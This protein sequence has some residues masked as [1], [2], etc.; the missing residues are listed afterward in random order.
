MNCLRRCL[1]FLVLWIF[2][3]C[4]LLPSALAADHI[5]RIFVNGKIWTGDDAHPSAEAL[6]I[7]GDKI[8]AVGTNAEIKKLS[9]ADT[10]VVDLHGRFVTPGFQDSHLHFPGPSINE[11]DLVGAAT[12]KDFQTRIADFAKAHP[13]VPWI[14]GSGWGYAIFPGQAP[15]KKYLDAILPDRPV[16]VT[17]R[18][19]H[20]GI[21]N[22]K[23]LAI[24][25]VDRNTP[26]PPNGRIM[27]D[28]QGEPTGEFKES[29]QDLIEKHI[30][31][32]TADDRYQS[33]L[34]HVDEAAAV[35]LTSV[36]NATWNPKNWPL[37]L[38]AASEG[39]LK[40]RFRFAPIILPKDGGAP[41][42]HKLKTPLTHDD[43]AYYRELRNTFR[44][45]YP[46]AN[47]KCLSEKRRI[48]L[49]VCL[50]DR[51]ENQNPPRGDGKVGIPRL[52]FW[53]DFHFSITPFSPAWRRTMPRACQLLTSSWCVKCVTLITIACVWSTVLANGASSPPRVCSTPPLPPCAS[54][55]AAFSSR[56]SA[57]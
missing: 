38:R 48:E 56:N 15:D 53:R 18:D 33:L 21:A 46:L 4:L 6:A 44:G 10:A 1:H 12:L 57:V 28:A 45:P 2:A 35:G 25:G 9:V 31:T 36:Q 29:A 17:E 52:C 40:L 42:E 41:L 47:L 26:D 37:Y 11:V 30:P 27:R 14:A 24:A 16:Y 54:G 39:K 19:G 34:Q 20:M 7:S 13:A 3:F 49:E 55:C 5:D 50:W 23:A 32:E 22:S 8:I 43:L 51:Q